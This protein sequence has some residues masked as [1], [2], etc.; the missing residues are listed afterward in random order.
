MAEGYPKVGAA[1]PKFKLP[2]S[3]GKTVDLSSLKG[4]FVVLY[5]YPRADTPGCT[6]E[7]CAFRDASADLAKA[8][9]VVLGVS[10]DPISEVEKFARKHK[11]NFPLLA[12]E[13]HTVCEKYGVWQ[14]KSMYGKKYFGAARTT[15]IIDPTGKI[16]H[17]FEKV[18]P[19]G[20]DQQV[21]EQLS[22]LTS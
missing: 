2:S 9:A 13:D 8:G 21:L 5:F 1:A 15:F 19:A 11:L 6:T 20:H 7:A 10:P 22:K 18:K 4:K 12:D 16:A 14:E 17:V 3:E